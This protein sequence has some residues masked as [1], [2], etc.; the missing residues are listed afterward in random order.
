[1]PPLTDQSPPPPPVPSC[2]R[3]PAC[4]APLVHTRGDRRILEFSPGDVQSEMRLSRP[5]ALVLAYCR[6]IMCFALFVPRPRAIVMVGLGGGSLAKFCYRHFPQAR[7]TVIELRA[8]V[9]ALREQFCVPPDGPR[10]KVVHADAVDWL[11]AAPACADV[12][13]IDGFD[14]AGLPPALGTARFYG[15]CRAALRD[16]GVLVANIFSYD[17]RYAGMLARLRLMFNDRVCWFERNAGNN[18]I[19]FAVKAPARLDSTRPLPRAL[20][21]QRWVARRQGLG[22]GVLNR[23]LARAVVAWLQHPFKPSK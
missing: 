1:M 19:L 23:L 3:G 9:I 4:G 20:R 6:A 11:A 16:G 14:S 12:L 15:D 18:R 10:F 7:I 5:E 22:S 13:V 2:E 17:P 21:L 8:D